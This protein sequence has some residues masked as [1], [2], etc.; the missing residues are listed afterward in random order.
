[1]SLKFIVIVS[2]VLPT[3]ALVWVLYQEFSAFG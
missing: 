1:M 3:A 2:C